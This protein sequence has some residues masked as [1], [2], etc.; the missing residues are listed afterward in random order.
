MASSI[1]I[2]QDRI[3]RSRLAGEPADILL[4]P[5][6]AAIGLLQFDRTADCIEEGRACVERHRQEILELTGA[7]RQAA[8]YL[9]R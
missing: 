1:N 4:S 7:A 3:T 9:R 8:T 2:M 6:L 5:Q